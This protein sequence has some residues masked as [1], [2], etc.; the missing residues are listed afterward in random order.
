[1][2]DNS[3]NTALIYASGHCLYSPVECLIKAKADLNVR[4]FRLNTALHKAVMYGEIDIAEL[5]ILNGADVNLKNKEG[6]I[7][8]ECAK[9]ED[10]RRIIFEVIKKVKGNSGGESNFSLNKSWFEK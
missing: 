5:L 9:N 10:D 8:L 3:G 2:R 4:G 1:M 7:A 6:N